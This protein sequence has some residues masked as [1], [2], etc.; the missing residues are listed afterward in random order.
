LAD[1]SAASTD[2]FARWF[3]I[4]DERVTAKAL[5]PRSS[6]TEAAMVTVT[7]SLCG[8]PLQLGRVTCLRRF[9]AL[10]RFNPWSLCP[11]VGTDLTQLPNELQMILF[12]DEAGQFGLLLPLVDGGRR[13]W[14][15]GSPGGLELRHHQWDRASDPARLLYAAS[16]PDP[17]ALVAD[18]VELL[19]DTL[20]TFRPRWRKVEPQWLNC[21]GWCTWDAFYREVTETGVLDGLESFKRCGVQP[22]FIMLDDGWLD[23]DDFTLKSL[24]AHPGKFPQGLQ[25][26]IERSKGEYG[27]RMFG[28][29]LAFQGYWYGVDAQTELGESYPLVS[30][31]QSAHNR[32][33]DPPA[34]R[35][36]VHPDAIA[37][38]YHDYYRGLR[39]A[40]V[41]WV[42]VDNQGSVDHFLNEE[43]VEPTP[44]MQ[45]YQEAFQ[46]ATAHHF[47]HESLH[48][49]SQVSDVLFHM[50]SANVMRNSEDYFPTRFETQGQH[51]YRNALN[52]VFM[53]AFCIP[54]WDMFQ[55]GTA[56]GVFHAAARAIS[57][58]PV[59]CSD[60]PG[61][62]D[63][64]ILQ[65]LCL[66]D[67]RALRC[68]QPALPTRDCIFEDANLNPVLLK[69]QNR[70]QHA[71]VLGLFNCH[72]HSSGGQAVNG[73]FRV[74][75]IDGI[76]GEQFALFFY[77]ARK[78]CTTTRDQ[79]H[80]INLNPLD[81]E[82][83]TVAPIQ[84]GAAIFGLADKFNGSAAL[85]SLSWKSDD[86]MQFQ[87]AEGGAIACWFERAPAGILAD[88]EPVPFDTSAT[89][90]VVI[91][92]PPTPDQSVRIAW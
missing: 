38:F 61:M 47:N 68:P 74:S 65:Q 9:M 62:Q 54:D 71:A 21:F 76:A 48:C 92:T 33:D 85:L 39:A 14:L 69:I 36:L 60:K 25:S 84:K 66:T 19:A 70:N 58:G 45:R 83:V 6:L 57:G 42:K 28:T 59:Y 3:G 63:A 29:W 11:V 89:G 32:P 64:A 2:L 79:S 88:G 56:T 91:H 31:N 26:L 4:G 23:A 49:L 13:A 18:S 77:H 82:L 24:S 80:P 55:S 7:G 75:D 16:G 8:Q 50:D 5:S 41:D 10:Q 81:W 44:T 15:A 20:R 35:H 67:G 30:T 73:Q 37:R 87:L 53:Q 22:R 90:L 40:G 46:A 43:T 12:E 27:I 1:K 78:A 34:P 72:Y 86:K 17:F 51:V 52:N